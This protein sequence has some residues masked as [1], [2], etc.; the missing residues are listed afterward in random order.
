M[1]EPA[2][3][4]NR[5]R[6]I[7]AGLAGRR[8][9]TFLVMLSIA[10]VT[11]LTWQQQDQTECNAEYNQRKAVADA[12][13]A[14]A[15]EADRQALERMVRAVVEEPRG[16]ERAALDEYLAALDKTDRQRRENPVPPPPPDLCR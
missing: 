12:A 4:S 5:I 16:D 7:G 15:A 9:I 8:F 10:A 6:R 13:I 14:D 2:K 3:R 11:Y 1:T